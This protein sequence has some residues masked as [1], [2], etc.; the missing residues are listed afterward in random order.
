[1]LRTF[2]FAGRAIVITTLILVV[3]F[4]P[5]ALSDYYSIWIM[6]TLLPAI[7]VV[8]LIADLLLVPSLAAVGWLRFSK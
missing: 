1:M 4:A 5:F 3:G 8:A 7:L 6:G 2:D